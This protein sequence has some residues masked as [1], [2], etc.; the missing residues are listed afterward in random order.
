MVLC[1]EASIKT[2]KDEVP[3]APGLV[4][5][6]WGSEKWFKVIPSGNCRRWEVKAREFSILKPFIQFVTLKIRHITSVFNY[7]KAT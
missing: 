2:Q 4:N 1:N 5:K 6:I 3:R 7:S